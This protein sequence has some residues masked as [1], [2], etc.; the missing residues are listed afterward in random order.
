MPRLVFDIVMILVGSGAILPWFWFTNRIAR[1][2]YGFADVPR[3]MA[4][5][6]WF[7]Q[8][9]GFGVVGSVGLGAWVGSSIAL[10]CMQDLLVYLGFLQESLLAP[11]TCFFIGSLPPAGVFYIEFRKYMMRYYERAKKLSPCCARCGYSLRGLPVRSGSIACPECGLA[12][13]AK[14]VIDRAESDQRGVDRLEH[15][16]GL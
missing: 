4:S 7:K 9:L 8:I 6:G 12:E 14:N 2:Y 13:S 5:F 10:Y 16:E 1:C 3:W 15:E 11:S